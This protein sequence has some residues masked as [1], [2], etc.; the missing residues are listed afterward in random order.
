MWGRLSVEKLKAGGERTHFSLDTM[1]KSGEPHKQACR[2]G[3]GQPETLHLLKCIL[4]LNTPFVRPET[5][6]KKEVKQVL[7]D[8]VSLPPLS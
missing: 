7:Q 6:D 3:A 8:Q 2:P 1:S 5:T 4:Q